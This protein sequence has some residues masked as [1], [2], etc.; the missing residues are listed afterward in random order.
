MQTVTY[1]DVLREIWQVPP[2]QLQLLFNFIHLLQEPA[3]KLPASHSQ[4]SA[5]LTPQATP[6][7]RSIQALEPYIGSMHLGEMN[8]IDVV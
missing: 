2:H 8:A 5:T 1:Q 3:P 7:T 6:K 4:S